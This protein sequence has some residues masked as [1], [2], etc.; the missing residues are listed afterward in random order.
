MLKADANVPLRTLQESP[1]L[2]QG[3]QTQLLKGAYCAVDA[4]GN[5]KGSEQVILQHKH[6]H[7]LRERDVLVE[8][9]RLQRRAQ[10]AGWLAHPV[11]P[12]RSREF[13]SYR[14]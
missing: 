14:R 3:L 12:K 13:P 4:V 8:P 9:R 10:A 11:C 2:G 1:K 6:A 5:G 7:P